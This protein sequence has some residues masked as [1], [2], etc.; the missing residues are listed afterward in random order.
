[1]D[2]LQKITLVVLGWILGLFTLPLSRDFE[3]KDECL[4]ILNNMRAGLEKLS[5]HMHRS[6]SENHYCEIL[7]EIKPVIESLN[8]KKSGLMFPSYLLNDLVSDSLAII[9]N[10]DPESENRLY[11]PTNTATRL[12]MVW[13]DINTHPVKLDKIEE[14]QKFISSSFPS[15]FMKWFGSVVLRIWLRIFD[16]NSRT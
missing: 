3:V 7:N 6:R 8:V 15:R 13:G 16:K 14:I 5:N 4:I 2:F 9:R 12:I 11:S 1:M 10:F